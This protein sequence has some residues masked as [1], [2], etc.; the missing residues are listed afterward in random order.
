MD[1]CWKLGYVTK[2]QMIN[3]VNDEHLRFLG[4]ILG[5]CF[6]QD[7]RERD[8]PII[9][10]C[11]FINN[12]HKKHHLAFRTFLTD[13]T[14]SCQQLVFLRSFITEKLLVIWILF[15]FIF[16]LAHTDGVCFSVIYLFGCVGS[17]MQHAGSSSCVTLL[18]HMGFFTGAPW[19]LSWAARGLQLQQG[20]FSCFIVCVII[21]PWPG[22]NSH[23][24]NARR[25]LH[26]W[27]SG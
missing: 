11:V 8:W 3:D 15:H 5:T 22:L 7:E 12:S 2:F 18:H 21:V 24:C 19:I 10:T 23:P 16:F 17:Q 20:A 6:L 9:K 13:C 14:K 1:C 4:H 26:H 27:T 25:I